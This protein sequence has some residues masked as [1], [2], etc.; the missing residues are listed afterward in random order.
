MEVIDFLVIAAAVYF[1]FT[2]FFSKKE[3]FIQGYNATIDNYSPAESKINYKEDYIVNNFSTLLYTMAMEIERKNNETTTI[4]PNIDIKEQDFNQALLAKRQQHV[5]TIINSF[6]EMF[7]KPLAVIEL[8]RSHG[9]KEAFGPGY[10][11]LL[12][13]VTITPEFIAYGNNQSPSGK[14]MLQ[15]HKKFETYNTIFLALTTSYK[16]YQVRLYGI[17]SIDANAQNGIDENKQ[18]NQSI[19]KPQQDNLKLDETESKQQA[20]DYITKNHSE[21][22]GKCFTQQGIEDKIEYDTM[23]Q[24]NGGI[25]DTPCK[26]DEECPYKEEG[27]NKDTGYCNM[28]KEIKNIS[29]KK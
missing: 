12:F 14:M 2:L 23:C 5:N 21:E 17:E 18:V 10:I 25:W 28:P 29:Y 1:I 22:E 8:D 15:K 3:T 16:V 4:T 6:N 19:I 24:L 27:C 11:Y 13:K 7:Q 20:Q 9:I 26:E